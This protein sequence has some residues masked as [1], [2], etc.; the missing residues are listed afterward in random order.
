[1]FR[2]LLNR[3]NL[4]GKGKCNVDLYSAYSWNL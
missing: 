2:Y 4:K 3:K 1:M